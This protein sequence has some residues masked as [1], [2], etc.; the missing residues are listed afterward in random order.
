MVYCSKGVFMLLSYHVH[1]K[2]SDGESSISEIVAHAKKNN[3]TEVGISDHF[4][5]SSYGKNYEW[6][7][8]NKNLDPYISEVQKFS[9]DF[10]VKLGLEADFFPETANELHKIILDRPFDYII[11]SV[12]FV[13]GI[14]IAEEA[15]FRSDFDDRVRQYWILIR[16]MA[17]SKIFDIVGHLDLPKKYGLYP[18]SDF[19]KEID[20]ALEAILNAKMCVELNTSGWHKPCKEQYPAAD[21]LKKCKKMNIPIIVSSDAHSSLH[22]IRDFEKAFSL[23]KSLGFEKQ[24]YYIKRKRFFSSFPSFS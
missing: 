9:R 4:T 8:P 21:L 17:E 16:Q 19:S 10:P 13:Y 15:G 23:L 18:K 11:G 6:S 14:D 2:W 12:H 24:P 1:S 22:L 3:L 20:L 5:L 7:M